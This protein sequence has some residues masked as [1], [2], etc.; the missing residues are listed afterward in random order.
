M[1]VKQCQ[2]PTL[3]ERGEH[4]HLLH[5]G[6]NNAHLLKTAAD[7]VSVPQLERIQAVM[8]ELP[9]DDNLLYALI[10]AMGGGEYWGDNSNG[11][12]FP[13][14]MPMGLNKPSLIH[15]PPGWERMSY[16]QQVAEGKR[17]EWGFPTF[18]NAK[19]FAHHKNKDPNRAFGDLVYVLWDD[20]MHRV[21]LIAAFDRARALERGASDILSRIDAGGFPSVSMGCKVPFDLCGYCTDWSRITGNPQIDLAEHRRLPIRGLSPTTSDYCEH[22]RTQLRKIY[23][24]GRKVKMINLHPRFFDLSV[25]FI[26]ADKTSYVLAKLAGE[27]P[28]RPGHKKCASCDQG[29]TIASSHVHEVWSRGETK[30]AKE[31][32]R[33]LSPDAAERAARQAST[34]VRVAVPAMG[35]VA[36][37]LAGGRMGYGGGNRRVTALTTALGALGLGGATH[38]ALDGKNLERH[39]IALERAA[40]NKVIGAARDAGYEVQFVNRRADVDLG[41]VRALLR[42]QRSSPSVTEKRAQG[43]IEELGF[44]DIDPATEARINNYLKR[45][46][47]ELAQRAKQ[48]S[49]PKVALDKDAEIEKRV[50]SNFEAKL[51]DLENAEPE[52]PL[53]TQ[54]A[55]ARDV[56]AA[57]ASAG[58]AGIVLK[59]KE[60]QRIIIIAMGRPGLADS[61]HREDRTFGP[62]EEPLP[63]DLPDRTLP[64][65][66]RM[67]L[68]MIMGRSAFGPP[69]HRRTVMTV[70]KGRDGAAA[71]KKDDVEEQELLKKIGGLYRGYRR[72]LIYK[73]AA[74]TQDAILQEPELLETVLGHDPIR[75]GL[76]KRGAAV[77]E[78]MLRTMPTTYLNRA[79]T[80]DPASDYVDQHCDLQG[81]KMAGAL[82]RIGGVA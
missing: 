2:F 66:L 37:G 61:L 17:W 4:L 76:A 56:P 55:M 40:A 9:K 5:P 30:M 19:T 58:G 51:P 69:L 47:T 77:L 7:T 34:A 29:T 62:G 16:Q 52:L 79:Y 11:D 57:L 75:S 74:L 28:L 82:A 64:H 42:A 73:V 71:E 14:R 43:G 49:A 18:Y 10:S 54:D 3:D 48:G 8:K 63:F 15:T 44:N 31:T 60:F 27:C 68:P 65:F 41:K 32:I 12:D 70:A 72:D 45:V 67:L 59:P 33:V 21:L 6:Y 26:G 80:G 23:P 13:E 39:S 1:I 46:R 25:V 38:L 22:I 35:A 20:R 36:G 78:S 81:L 53:E 24:D 50:K